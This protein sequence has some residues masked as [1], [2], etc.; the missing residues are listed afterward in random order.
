MVLQVSREVLERAP[1]VD[2]RTYNGSSNGIVVAPVPL[3]GTVATSVGF[4]RRVSF[5]NYQPHS[6]GHGV[7]V[8]AHS[9]YTVGMATHVAIENT[10]VS[11]GDEVLVVTGANAGQVSRVTEILYTEDYGQST[12]YGIRTLLGT[13]RTWLAL[14]STEPWPEEVVRAVDALDNQPSNADDNVSVEDL[15]ISEWWIKRIKKAAKDAKSKYGYCSSIDAI[16]RELFSPLAPKWDVR[17]EDGGW[18][19]YDPKGVKHA[20]YLEE[21]RAR[22]EKTKKDAKEVVD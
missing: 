18:A 7:R 20:W 15:Q 21:S 14:N 6:R 12:A 22:S 17:A 5:S 19:V 9:A 11:V 2:L 8:R 3:Y 4:G 16:V 10:D 1:L 13:H